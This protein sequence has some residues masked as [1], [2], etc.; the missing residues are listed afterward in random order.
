M[1][2]RRVRFDFH[3][4][5]I[6]IYMDEVKEKLKYAIIILGEECVVI[7]GMKLLSH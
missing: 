2:A 4:F 7:V 3:I 6:V 1:A 5:I